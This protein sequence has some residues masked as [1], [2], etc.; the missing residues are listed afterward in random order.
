MPA[1]PTSSGRDPC[2]RV[3]VTATNSQAAD[4]P[5]DELGMHSAAGSPPPA[6]HNRISD[7]GSPLTPSGWKFERKMG[8]LFRP[9]AGFIPAA[10]RAARSQSCSEA[11]KPSAGSPPPIEMASASPAG[12]ALSVHGGM[13][14]IGFRHDAPRQVPAEPSVLQPRR[15]QSGSPLKASPLQARRPLDVYRAAISQSS[16]NKPLAKQ[17]QPPLLTPGVVPLGVPLAVSGS[18]PRDRAAARPPRRDRDCKQVP[19][20]S[21]HLFASHYV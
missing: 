13:S 12:A 5:R 15:H 10:S 19:R 21:T 3:V 20:G 16:A 2:L 18:R 4:Q 7:M 11:V 8:N 17:Q 14:P 9:V 1:L 6:V